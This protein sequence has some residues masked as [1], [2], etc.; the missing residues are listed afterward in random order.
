MAIAIQEAILAYMLI[1]LH[2]HNFAIVPALDLDIQAGF[3]AITVE[4]GAV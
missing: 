3:T 2:I 1:H 4:T